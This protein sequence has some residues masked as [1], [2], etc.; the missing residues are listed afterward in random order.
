MIGACNTGQERKKDMKPLSAVY[1]IK[2]NKGRAVIIIFMMFL[3]TFLFLGGNYIRSLW[4]YWDK[5]GEYSEN[6]AVASALPTDED[7]SDYESFR[8][9]VM[10]DEKL[11]VLGRT[12]YGFGG[13]QWTSTLG[14]KMG[15]YSY[16]F[17]SVEDMKKAFDIL[18]IECDYSNL[19]NYSFVM[20]RAYA[21]NV[22]MKLGDMIDK[23]YTLDALIDDDSFLIFYIYE[24]EPDD[25]YRLN[26]MSDEMT[27][28]ELYDY[29]EK[30]KAGRKVDISERIMD[31][32][33]SEM[34]VAKIIFLAA[35][36]IVS[37]KLAVTLNSVVTG[38]YIKRVY[39]FGVY[40]AL[41]IPKRHIKR[42]IRRELLL[43][44][45]IAVVSGV[46][47]MLLI[48]FLLNE[49]VYIPKGQYLPY[50]SVM[51]VIGVL[52]SNILVVV[53]M[54]FLKGRRM[55]KADVTEF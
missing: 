9:D 16:V 14:F 39:E 17:N 44:D 31:D 22:G 46:A 54:I 26:I 12:G 47:F 6:I 25:F 8:R 49:L 15:S 13:K 52:L 21:T 20:S 37:V 30:L 48:T 50:F 7:G 23:T 41:G 43:M 45:L 35:L 32:V 40:R 51:G 38:Q 34:G 18:G 11:T 1:Y 29:V 42:K 4:W 24:V 2:N 27:G 3:T 55:C 53:P 28:D 5:A 36:V 33:N 10:A 19:K